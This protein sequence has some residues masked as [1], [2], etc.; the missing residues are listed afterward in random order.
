MDNKDD[1]DATD[2]KW[3]NVAADLAVDELRVAKL[4]S[5]D[6]AEFARRIV[7]QQLHIMSISGKRP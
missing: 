7:S 3:S 5:A 2:L 6:E 4:I 1:R